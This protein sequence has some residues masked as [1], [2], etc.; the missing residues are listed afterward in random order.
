MAEAEGHPVRIE[1]MFSAI[2]PRYD[3]LNRLLSLGRDRTWRREAA[4]RAALPPGGTALDICT[5]TAD[6]ALELAWQYPQ[7]AGIVG[8]D[9]SSPMIALGREKVARTGLSSR[10]RLALGPAE[11]LPFSEGAFDA[12]L[13][14]FGLRN[15]ADRTQGL[16]EMRRVVKPGGRAIVLEFAMPAGGMFGAL[17]RLYLH[18]LLPLIGRIVSGHPFAYSYLPASVAEF[19]D[20]AELAQMMRAIGFRRAD[21]ALLTGGIVALHVAIK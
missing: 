15:L 8:V 16:A 18:R 10:V 11:S 17:Y 6:L 20:P 14:A 9:F 21:Y 3:L 4:R 13:V 19:P 1:R 2:A 7:A 12:A 5:G